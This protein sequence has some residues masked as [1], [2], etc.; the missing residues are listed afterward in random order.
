MISYEYWR[1]NFNA[2]RNNNRTFLDVK[3]VFC[4]L[5]VEER[6]RNKGWR[7]FHN[8]LE[9]H[10][11]RVQDHFV[12]FTNNGL[13]RDGIS[14]EAFL[15]FLYGGRKLQD[16]EGALYGA[17]KEEINK[18]I[19]KL[20]QACTQSLTD[21]VDLYLNRVQHGDTLR[22]G[23]KNRPTVLKVLFEWQWRCLCH[24]I[25]EGP[26]EVYNAF[27][28]FIDDQLR[29][30][31]NDRDDGDNDGNTTTEEPCQEHEPPATNGLSVLT[32]DT[33][34]LTGRLKT[35]HE[36][37]AS[38]IQSL[39]GRVCNTSLPDERIPIKW[40]VIS[41]QSECDKDPRNVPHQLADGFRRGWAVLSEEYIHSC[42]RTGTDVGTGEY[43]LDTTKLSDAPPQLMQSLRSLPVPGK[44]RR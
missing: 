23:G 7:P 3:L 32:H 25:R 22:G 27:D 30:H 35:S 9:Q 36:R 41:T 19:A 33:F 38:E 44:N 5:G 20:I 40:V 1:D 29:I 2:T 26:S 13:M 6:R 15:T 21:G 34:I 16:R 4:F 24:R 39:G 17:R 31:N 43:L 37:L 42:K 11:F 14:L 18:E 28:E 10:G 8:F 12:S